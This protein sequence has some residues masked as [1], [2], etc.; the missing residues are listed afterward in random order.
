[1]GVVNLLP[2]DM[3]NEHEGAR[4]PEASRVCGGEGAGSHN[5]GFRSTVANTRGVSMNG[6]E[7]WDRA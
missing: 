5:G 2:V 7:N 3:I 6:T 4:L 1:M